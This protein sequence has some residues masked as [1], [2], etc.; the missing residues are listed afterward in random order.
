MSIVFKK[1]GPLTYQQLPADAAAYAAAAESPQ[2]RSRTMATPANVAAAARSSWHPDDVH[3][4]RMPHHDSAWKRL[5][6]QYRVVEFACTAVMFG[7]SLFFSLI[8][9]FQRDIPYVEVRLSLNQTVWARAPSIDLVKGKEQVPMVMLVGG[10]V[11]LPILSNLFLNFVL[12]KFKRVRVIPH[13]TRDFLLS[14]FQSAGLSALLTQFIKNQTGRFRPSFYDMCGWNKDVIWDGV[15]NLC[16]LPHWEKEGRKSFP[17]GHAS[18]AWSTMLVLTLYL[19]GRSRLNAENRSD[20]ILRGGRKALKLFVCFA[21]SLIAAWVSVTRSVDNW[22]HYS[23]ILAGSIIGA[24]SATIAY[25]YNYGSVFNWESAGVPY[26][27]YHNRRKVRMHVLREQ[28]RQLLQKQ[29]KDR[30]LVELSGGSDQQIGSGDGTL[31]RP[32]ASSST[33]D[34]L[35]KP[36]GEFVINVSDNGSVTATGSAIGGSQSHR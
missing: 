14:L 31:A 6:L 33:H 27:E 19:L 5:V 7:F 24:V 23:D 18:F 11:A 36:T 4:D 10:G 12:P 21:P 29:R 28:R 13:D 34:R 9:V 2:E 35:R 26:Q 30:E 20:S 25:G 15:S 22:H 16:S 1:H 17:S 32:A 8:E 3:A